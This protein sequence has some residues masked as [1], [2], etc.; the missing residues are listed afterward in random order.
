[1]STII[2]QLRPH[3]WTKNILVMVPLLA[4]HRLETETLA[5]GLL[6]F[7]AFSMLASCVYILN[8]WLDIESDRKHPTKRLRPLASGALSK[9]TALV[10]MIVLLA[11]TTAIAVFEGSKIFPVY[12]GLYLLVNVLYSFKAKQLLGLDAVCLALLYTLRILAGGAA[13]GVP[14]TFWLMTFS[15]FFFLSLALL[16]RTSELVLSGDVEGSHR[17]AYVVGDIEVIVSLGTSASLVSGLVLLLYLNS[18]VNTALYHRPDLLWFLLPVLFYWK[19]RIWILARRGQIAQDPVAYALKDRVTWI[20][21]A[22]SGL[23]LVLAS[24]H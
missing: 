2:R 22:V 7:F 16:K 24:L 10:M 3:Q 1:M 20:L 12:L 13:A 11:G 8:D 4:A 23:V 19:L 14:V 17:R 21:V 15:S 6:A 5:K 9:S 18:P